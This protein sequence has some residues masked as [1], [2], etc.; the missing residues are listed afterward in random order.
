MKTD[1]RKEGGM[2]EMDWG[3]RNHLFVRLDALH[4]THPFSL[5]ASQLVKCSWPVLIR[6]HNWLP[7]ARKR[8]RWWLRRRRWGE[9]KKRSAVRVIYHENQ[10]DIEINKHHKQKLC[11][12]HNKVLGGLKQG[13]HLSPTHIRTHKVWPVNGFH[14]FFLLEEK[15]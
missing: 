5:M 12:A 15:R 8:R 7:D 14:E 6:H 9:R 4:L 2:R 3:S 13:S 1:V 11:R 10:Q